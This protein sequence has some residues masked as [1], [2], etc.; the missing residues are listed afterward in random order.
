MPSHGPRTRL[1]HHA[2]EYLARR[3][4]K[5]DYA[6][7]RNYRG[8]LRPL[9]QWWDATGKVPSS[10]R[11]PDMDSYVW[12]R[13]G[14]RAKTSSDA[15]LNHWIEVI[16]VFVDWAIRYRYLAPEVREPLATVKP[17]KPARR[18]LTAAQLADFVE[19]CEDPWE[20]VVCALAVNTAG[21]SSELT[22]A[23]LGDVDLDAGLIDWSRI[24]TRDDTDSL[25]ITADLDVEL[26]RWFDAYEQNCGPLSPRWYLVPH[27]RKF[28][29]NPFVYNPMK[30]RKELWTVAK[31]HLARVLGVDPAELKY[32]GVHTLRRSMARALYEQLRGE[33][34]GDPLAVVQSLLGH[35]TRAMS[36]RYI[37]VQS[38]RE[39]RDRVLR[40]RSWRVTA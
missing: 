2:D 25:P 22:A 17:K 18:R 28:G 19:G 23:R 3:A 27:R 32:E 36:E 21:R 20:R 31:G 24:K 7:I 9:C 40:G 4:A 34:Y 29:P 8:I 38:T 13:H 16:R 6:T 33:G 10:M 26:R 11:E 35:T 14:L 5:L 15:T 37:G 12:G 39:E 1:C 30:P